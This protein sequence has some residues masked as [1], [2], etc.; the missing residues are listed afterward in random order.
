MS[1]L[2]IELAEQIQNLQDD[3]G[4][5]SFFIKGE[6]MNL[7]LVTGEQLATLQARCAGLTLIAQLIKGIAYD[8]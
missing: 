5:G 6:N 2:L 4:I 1:N 8:F 3:K 7:E